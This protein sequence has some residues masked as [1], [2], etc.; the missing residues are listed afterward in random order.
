[1][2]LTINEPNRCV[3]ARVMRHRKSYKKDFYFSDYPTRFAAIRAAKLWLKK[4]SPTLPPPKSTKN[5]MTRRNTSGVVGVYF[6][7][8]TIKRG[9]RLYESKSWVARWPGC[10]HSGGLSWSIP[11]YGDNESYVLAVLSRRAESINR[12]K[13][14]EEM[15]AIKGTSEYSDILKLLRTQKK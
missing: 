6:S 2:N 4:I 9:D 12:R 8:H 10:P 5:I 7:K 14:I 3:M 11:Y 1:M 15:D 13:I